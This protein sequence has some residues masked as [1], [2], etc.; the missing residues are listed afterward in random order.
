MAEQLIQEHYPW[1]WGTFQSYDMEVKK[2]DAARVFI[3]HRHGG[4]YL[5]LDVQCYRA[6]DS[7]L[8]DLDF[9]VQGC[10]WAPSRAW[11]AAMAC[12]QLAFRLG[13]TH[14]SPPGLPGHAG[15]P[16]GC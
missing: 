8:L 7:M 2:A 4:L 11:Q 9:A 3:L 12:K 6:V 14:M 15:R 5:D 10:A 13:L 1:F 16:A